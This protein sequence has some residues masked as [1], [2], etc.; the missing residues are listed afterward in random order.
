MVLSRFWEV[1]KVVAFLPLWLFWGDLMV[2][3]F[4][5]CLL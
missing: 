3:G 1:G 5:V 2:V 4:G